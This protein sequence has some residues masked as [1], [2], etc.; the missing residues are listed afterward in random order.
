MLGEVLNTITYDIQ[1]NA[2]KLNNRAFLHRILGECIQ[3]EDF[4]HLFVDQRQQP[5][6][7]PSEFL[8][9]DPLN[10]DSLDDEDEQLLQ[11][12]DMDEESKFNVSDVLVQPNTIINT[13][14]ELSDLNWNDIQSEYQPGPFRA[15]RRYVQTRLEDSW[16][17][18]LRGEA[19]NFD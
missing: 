11:R 9:E 19:R 1:A 4:P 14:I 6:I 5:D 8:I 16:N 10:I 13:D 3:R 2:A 12:L 7:N 17:S 18:D 15:V